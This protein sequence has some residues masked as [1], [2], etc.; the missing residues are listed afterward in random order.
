MV[1]VQLLL[2]HFPKCLTARRGGLQ[3]GEA[4]YRAEAVL[5]F[6]CAL[7]GGSVMFLHLLISNFSMEP[8]LHRLDHAPEEE[9]CGV[10]SP[11]L[12]YGH[13]VCGV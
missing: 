11:F 10:L 8:D 5:W 12:V 1:G 2:V 6:W 3:W 4:Q 13:S 9:L 7:Q